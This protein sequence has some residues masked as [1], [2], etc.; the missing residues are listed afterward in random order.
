[1]MWKLTAEDE[2]APSVPLMKRQ[3]PVGMKFGISRCKS[4]ET[5][6]VDVQISCDT[7]DE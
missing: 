6:S 4:K 2:D 3:I 7:G 5:A 1:M